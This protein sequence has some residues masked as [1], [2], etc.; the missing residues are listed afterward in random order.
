MDNNEY[1]VFESAVAPAMTRAIA[2]IRAELVANGHVCS[3]LSQV[4]HDFERGFGFEL[5]H[6]ASQIPISVEFM[7][8]DGDERGFGRS[9]GKPECGLLLSV[10]GPDG[11]FLGDW[12]PFNYSDG[13]GTCD[14]DEAVR[15]VELLEPSSVAAS[16][17]GRIADW[18]ESQLE[19]CE[20]P[21]A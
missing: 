16:I 21:R 20:A 10:I 17:H 13:V 3:D 11:V 9:D 18:A 8:T 4:D 5:E 2:A 7:L 12:C 19:A 6:P 15:R 1:L 14:P